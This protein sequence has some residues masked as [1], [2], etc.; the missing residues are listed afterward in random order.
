MGATET[1]VHSF[2]STR[3]DYFNSL[4]IGLPKKQIRTLQGLQ[5]TVARLVNNTDKYDHIAYVAPILIRRTSLT[6]S[7][8]HET[9]A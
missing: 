9:S 2:V 6:P 5:N 8:P 4:D 3:L 7:R 1:L